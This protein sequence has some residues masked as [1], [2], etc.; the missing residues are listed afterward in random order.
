MMEKCMY[1]CLVFREG[2]VGGRV[3]QEENQGLEK[4]EKEERVSVW[5]GQENVK[6]VVRVEEWLRT[7]YS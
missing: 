1:R 2:G 7:Y 6:E 3:C 4:E 5:M